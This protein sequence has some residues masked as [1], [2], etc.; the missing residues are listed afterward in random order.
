MQNSMR[1]DGQLIDSLQMVEF[2]T[3]ANFISF[4]NGDNQTET[5]EGGLAEVTDRGVL[6][7]E[8]DDA[9]HSYGSNYHFIPWHQIY[10]FSRIPLS[11]NG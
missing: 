2:K 11:E 9:P 3:K 7:I 4:K 10:S 1:V 8:A 6:W 5:M